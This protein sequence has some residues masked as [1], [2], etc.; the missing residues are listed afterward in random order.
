MI[1]LTLNGICLEYDFRALILTGL[2]AAEV[3]ARSKWAIAAQGEIELHLGV[4]LFDRSF[5]FTPTRLITERQ[6]TIDGDAVFDWLIEGCYRMPRSEV[7]GRDFRGKD[8]Q[9][10]ARDIDVE[11]SPIA[12]FG[13][14]IWIVA[15]V[16]ID[17]TLG[18][19][20][21]PL[22]WPKRLDRTEQ[23]DQFGKALRQYRVGPD[24]DWV[25]QLNRWTNRRSGFS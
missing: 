11:E 17:S 4:A 12:V 25:K 1:D 5:I 15:V 13:Y 10:F 14:G 8:A 6:Q 19:E 9:V 3:A 7:F 18:A 23:P 24:I 21:Y 20:V 16:D 22:D 2:G